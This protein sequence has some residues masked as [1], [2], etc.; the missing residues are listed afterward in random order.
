MRARGVDG[1]VVALC[2][3]FARRERVIAERSEPHRVELEYRY[4][5]FKIMSAAASLC[6]ERDGRVLIDEIGSET[7][8]AGSALSYY[9]EISYKRLKRAVKDGIATS[10]N[11]K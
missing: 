3:D 10:L 4:L 2:A 6:G 9:S 8:Y 7:G 5:N 1:I 11:L